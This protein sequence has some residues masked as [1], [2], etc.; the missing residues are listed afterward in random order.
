MEHLYSSSITGHSLVKACT[1][2]NVNSQGLL[3]HRAPSVFSGWDQLSSLVLDE[4]KSPW[5]QHR[6]CILITLVLSLSSLHLL[7]TCC[8]PQRILQLPRTS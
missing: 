2:G 6:P 1:P 8:S 3:A 5:D 7:Y 4:S